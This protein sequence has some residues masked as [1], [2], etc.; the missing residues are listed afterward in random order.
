[1]TPAQLARHYLRF[2]VVDPD[3]YS[4]P[5]DNAPVE[6]QQLVNRVGAPGDVYLMLG[7]IEADEIPGDPD[8]DLAL[9]WLAANPQALKHCDEF[10]SSKKGKKESVKFR[11]ILQHAYNVEHLATYSKVLKFLQQQTTKS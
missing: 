3:H 7:F 4:R 1:M 6:L 2:W 8:T 11:D 10:L 9:L 5:T